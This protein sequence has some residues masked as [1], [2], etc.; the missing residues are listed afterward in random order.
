MEEDGGL[1]RPLRCKNDVLIQSAKRITKSKRFKP[2][3]S[4]QLSDK[5][6]ITASNA[7]VSR[8]SLGVSFSPEYLPKS[9]EWGAPFSEALWYIGRRNQ[10]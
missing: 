6:N 8:L 7:S 3:A 5:E 1:A 9:L 2:A 10:S 4:Y